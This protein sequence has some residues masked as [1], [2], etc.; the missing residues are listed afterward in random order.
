MTKHLAVLDAAGLIKRHKKGRT[1]FVTLDPAPLA[2]LQAWAGEFHTH[3]GAGDGTYENYDHYLTAPPASGSR[4][5]KG[6]S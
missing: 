2:L 4:R 3:W 6:S 5:T 1:T